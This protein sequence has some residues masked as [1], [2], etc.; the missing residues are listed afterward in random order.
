VAEVFFDKAADVAVGYYGLR[1]AVSL[2]LWPCEHKYSASV[3]AIGN[4]NKKL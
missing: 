4:N 1:R 3:V 2:S